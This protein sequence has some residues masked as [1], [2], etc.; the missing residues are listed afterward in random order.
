MISF[1]EEEFIN[2]YIT[3]NHSYDETR[4]HF[5]M[6]CLQLN[7]YLSEHGLNKQKNKEFFEDVIKRVSKEEL[8]NYYVVEN[9][10]QEETCK[11][12]NVTQPFLCRLM[13]HYNLKKQPTVR[14]I[15]E[16][17]LLVDKEKFIASVCDT[18]VSNTSF[19]KSVGIT[20]TE[21]NNLR[22]YFGV[23]TQKQ[24]LFEDV[25]NR[26][27]KEDFYNYY[28]VEKHSND[29]V[30]E[31]FSINKNTLKKLTYFYNIHKNEKF[32]DVYK[33][34]T[35]EEL[36]E[37]YVNGEHDYR[38]TQEHFKINSASLDRLMREYGL[39]KRNFCG[40][41]VFDIDKDALYDYYVLQNHTR[42]ETA[43]FFGCSPLTIYT[44]TKK[45]GFRKGKRLG[46]EVAL[47]K[48]PRDEL[49][50]RY[51]VL[52]EDR[53][54]LSDYF[55]VSFH[56]MDK[57]IRYYGVQ[58]IKSFD[59]YK[60]LIRKEDIQKHYIDENWS[61]D[62][63]CNFFDVDRCMFFRLCREY[64][65]KY[66]SGTSWYEDDVIANLPK[67]VVV[68]KKVRGVL[69]NKFEIDVFLPEYK[70]G[71][72]FNG[73][74]WHSSLQKEKNY[75]FNKSKMAE[76]R[77]I[78]L[79]HIY[80]Y[81]WNDPK[82]QE[83]II[84][85][86]NIATHNVKTR[87]YAR[88]CV[89]KKITNNEAKPFNEANHL[90]GH[91]NAQVTYGL[92]YNDELVQLMSFSK[93]KYNKNNMGDNDWEIIRGC[94]GS[95][96]I[97]VG[98]V[99]RLFKHFIREYDPDHVFSYCDFNKFDGSGYEALGMKFVGY[100]GP[101]FKWLLDVQQLIVVPRNPKK[102]KELKEQAVAKIWGAG[103]KKYLWSNPWLQVDNI[104]ESG[105]STELSLVRV[106]GAD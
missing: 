77:G 73:S 63:C 35:R 9:H 71:I 100:T 10:F 91:R 58:K 76:E 4:E 36:I 87:I 1:S 31:F 105:Y 46:F 28:I 5:K 64:G 21:F 79:I 102:H 61:A 53:K 69:P 84:S 24:E 56:H 106:G 101:D 80:E 40:S 7:H 104:S 68:L 48:V 55:N 83:K 62:E 74:Y 32:S 92:F 2:Y 51:K 98:G 89:V 23:P 42:E 54:K 82:T 45:Y 38:E 67:N 12:F 13:R 15:D 19:M 27:T 8:Y 18:K 57:I 37:Y 97:V 95:N 39:V 3:D 96:N 88:Q 6:S 90:Q 26:I 86:L 11:H 78:R 22:K 66:K 93:T 59:E 43:D 72:E 49:E 65:I 17:L 16:L 34:I 30:C 25:V 81:E 85:M 103:S 14:S 70:I 60:E 99:S 41:S 44:Y 50:Y 20:K 47:K 94:P 52:N 33:R 29:E 75:H